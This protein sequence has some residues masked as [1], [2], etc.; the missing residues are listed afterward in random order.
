MEKN[1]ETPEL[2]LIGEA[3]ELVLGL[4]IGGNDGVGQQTAPDFEFEQD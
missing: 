3:N 1:Y 2:L 4:G